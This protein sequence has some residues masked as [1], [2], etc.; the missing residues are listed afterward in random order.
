MS[1]GASALS[2]N[3]NSIITRQ[4]WLRSACFQVFR[5]GKRAFREG[6]P[7]ILHDVEVFAPCTQFCFWLCVALFGFNTEDTEKSHRGHRGFPGGGSLL[8][9]EE[10]SSSLSDDSDFVASPGWIRTS[11]FR[12]AKERTAARPKNGRPLQDQLPPTRTVL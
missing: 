4:N 1:A 6:M 5:A 11:F 7:P 8:V 12:N 9:E 10:R 3:P 2:Q